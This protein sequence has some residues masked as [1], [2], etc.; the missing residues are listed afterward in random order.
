MQFETMTAE[1]ALV[2]DQLVQ[3]LLVAKGE[4]EDGA[5]QALQNT[6]RV[7]MTIVDAGR[8]CLQRPDILVLAFVTQ[9]VIWYDGP[10]APPTEHE[11]WHEYLQRET[12]AFLKS[13]ASL[14]SIIPHMKS[15]DIQRIT[16]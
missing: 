15:L 16:C 6:T 1:E 10:P 7:E 3:V 14:L 2:F 13:A 12:G 5:W 4:D 11:M 8:K 9:L